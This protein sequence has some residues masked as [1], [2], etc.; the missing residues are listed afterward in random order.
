MPIYL[1][2]GAEQFLPDLCNVGLA[3]IAILVANPPHLLGQESVIEALLYNL[4]QSFLGITNQQRKHQIY[5]EQSNL[6]TG[7][8]RGLESMKSKGSMVIVNSQRTLLVGVR[9]YQMKQKHRLSQCRR[10]LVGDSKVKPHASSGQLSGR[11]LIRFFHLLKEVI[12]TYTLCK[13][14]INIKD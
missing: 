12:K 14:Y 13:L 11:G 6:L 1:L 5:I 4:R 7:I 10:W 2:S 3:A 8:Q 9:I